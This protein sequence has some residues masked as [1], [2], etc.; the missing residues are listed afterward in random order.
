MIQVVIKFFRTYYKRVI[1]SIAF[2]PAITALCFLLLSFGMV[3]FDFSTTGKNIKSNLHWLSLKDASTARSICSVIA[4]GIISL[5]VF[6]FSMVMILLN[7]AAALMSNRILG[8]LIGNRFQQFV[9]GFYVGTIVYALFLLSTIRDINTGIYVPAISTYLLIGLTIIDIFLFIYFLHYITQSVK[10]ETI[11]HNIYSGT[12]AA[13]KK[14]CVLKESHDLVNA[15]SDGK[16]FGAPRSGL[17]QGFDAD[18]L[19]SLCEKEDAVI[20]FLYPAG[21]YLIE[22]TPL[23]VIQTKKEL[24]DEHKD[25]LSFLLNIERGQEIEVN[26]DYGMRQLMEIALKA[27]SPG[28]N[29]PGTA[30]ISLHALGSLLVFRMKHIPEIFLKDKSGVTRIIIKE[31]TFEELFEQYILPIWDYGKEDRLIQ[32]EM[33]HILAQLNLNGNFSVVTSTIQSVEA[34]ILEKRKTA[35][36]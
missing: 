30:I 15:P 23:L 29:D 3:Q 24:S 9:L 2:I 26:Y 16:W 6:S 10:Y 36:I 13:I 35:T 17:F 12:K 28:I 11:I 1:S 20:Y 18:S 5:S 33:L 19:L 14:H 7:Q 32:K 31:K 27:L 22:E 8:K 25:R 21:T 4:G 34:A